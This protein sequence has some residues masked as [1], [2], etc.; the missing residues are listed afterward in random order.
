M[1]AKKNM[2]RLRLLN[3]WLS[4]KGKSVKS[5]R[6]SLWLFGLNGVVCIIHS[7]LFSYEMQKFATRFR[8]SGNDSDAVRCEFISK[9]MCQCQKSMTESRHTI[10][11][12][13]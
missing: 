4:Q 11:R 13:K 9:T 6:V 3:Q 2:Q 8:V 10:L 5:D 7:A 12:M 1:S